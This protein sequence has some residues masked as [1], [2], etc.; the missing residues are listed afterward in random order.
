VNDTRLPLVCFG[1]SLT[2]G[3]G[4]DMDESFPDYLQQDLDAAG[5]SYHV[6]NEGVSGNTTKDGLTRLPHLLALKPAVVIVELGG[7]DG[8]RGLSVD[9]TQSNLDAI[10]AALTSAKI[11]VVLGGITLPPNYGSTYIQGFDHIYAALAKKYHVPLLPFVLSNVF[12]VPGSMQDD[13]IH[14]TAQGNQQVAKN[15]LP[16]LKPLLKK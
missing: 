10:L 7:N 16:Y 5:Y 4:V 13:G 3:Y 12:G 15:F 14:A 11:R 9:Q 8:L 6:L 1:D 2:A